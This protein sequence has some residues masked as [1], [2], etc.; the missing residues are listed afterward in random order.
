MFFQGFLNEE[1]I[2]ITEYHRPE[3]LEEL[4]TLVSRKSPRT[5][6]LGGGLYINEVIKEPI[7]VA[8]KSKGPNSVS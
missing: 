3:N 8:V 1:L 6:V 7:A 4:F 5:I 2:M